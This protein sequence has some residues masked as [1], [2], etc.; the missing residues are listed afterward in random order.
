MVSPGVTGSS[1][2][3]CQKLSSI[4][5]A[6]FPSSSFLIFCIK[7]KSQKA[8]GVF[9]SMYFGAMRLFNI[10]LLRFFFEKQSIFLPPKCS[11]FNLFDILQQT[12]FSK[13]PKGPHFTG[14]KILRFLSL[15]YSADF[16]RS[17]LNETYFYRST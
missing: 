4:F 9:H 17:R 16:R 15:T 12:A 5:L 7:P 10:L 13:S 14:V 1:P 11:P 2:C 6:L 8:Q 3:F